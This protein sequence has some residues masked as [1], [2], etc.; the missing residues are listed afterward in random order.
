MTETAPRPVDD[1]S[2][3]PAGGAGA[4]DAPAV[5]ITALFAEAATKSGLMWVQPPGDRA[6]PFWHAWADDTVYAVS[7]PGEQTLPWLP[8]EVVLLLRSK[9]NGGRL[10]AVHATCEEV[11][12]QDERWAAATAALSAARLNATDDLL[13]RWAR[14]CTVRAMKPF[15]PPLEAPGSYGTGSGAAPVPPSTATTTHWRPWHLRGRPR[16]RRGTRH[17]DDR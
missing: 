4:A 12:P 17:P 14:E 11:A 8:G 13:G 9:D 1:G 3:P 2:P 5:N 10:L 16:R 6:W 15:G 7:G